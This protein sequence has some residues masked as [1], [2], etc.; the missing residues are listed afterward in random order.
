LRLRD[1]ER[2][3][4]G[5]HEWQVITGYGHA[6]EHASLY[7]AE[8]EVLIAGD[9]LLPRISTNVSAFAAAP[10]NDPLGDFLASIDR[11]EALPAETLVLPSHGRPFRGLHARVAQLH[12]H[13]VE[14]CA[15]LRQA[16]SEAPRTAAELMPLL[17]GRAISDPHQTMFAM[18]EAIAHLIYLEQAGSLNRIADHGTIRFVSNP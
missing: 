13:H 17:F 3:A 4:I 11:F 2:I 1:G 18:G 10:A 15:V 14:R 9:M 8:L 16:C 5:A 7:C 6:A 12:A